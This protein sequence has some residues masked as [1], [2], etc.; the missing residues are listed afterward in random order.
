MKREKEK[1]LLKKR[2]KKEK[3]ILA[4]KNQYPKRPIISARGDYFNSDA[5]RYQPFLPSQRREK[6]APNH[7]NYNKHT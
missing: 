3:G 5:L 6:N 4:P 7:G 1:K 2:K